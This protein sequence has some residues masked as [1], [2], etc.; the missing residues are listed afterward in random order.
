MSGSEVVAVFKEVFGEDAGRVDAGD[1][2]LR[3]LQNLDAQG[4]WQ[5]DQVQKMLSEFKSSRGGAPTCAEDV[6]RWICDGMAAEGNASDKPE[7]VFVLGGPGSGKGTFSARCVEQWG[8][9]HLSAGDCIRAERQREGSPTAE[10]IEARL[11]EGKLI[12]SEVTV[13]LLQQEMERQC[14]AGGKYLIDG[15]PRSV[16]NYETWDRIVGDKAKL[17]FVLLIECSEEVMMKRL[18]KR[19]ET[20][21]R[22]DDNADTIRKRFQTHLEEAVPV[23]NKLEERG[24]V[25]KVNSDPG[26]DA[27]WH[28]VEAIFAA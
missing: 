10:L 3:V 16:D 23:Q 11:K 26:I 5:A 6:L 13:S 28:E 4:Q 1:L 15:F 20:S 12:P 27:V 9:R 14:W 24:L 19:G 21:G 8:F 25:R 22:S 7:V 18:L 2:L 17:K